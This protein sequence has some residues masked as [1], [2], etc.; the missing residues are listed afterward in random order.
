MRPHTPHELV[1]PGPRARHW[2]AAL[3]VFVLV[4]GSVAHF[5]HHLLDPHCD[6]GARPG[7]HPCVTCVSMH[8]AA[9]VSE[10]ITAAPPRPHLAAL[11]PAPVTAA[12]R[13]IA[14]PCGGPRAPP[15][16]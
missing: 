12:P 7:S 8:G 5:G 16:G 14:R 15:R 3:L 6:D 9:L 2:T 13:A 11:V 10:A 4:L 1:F